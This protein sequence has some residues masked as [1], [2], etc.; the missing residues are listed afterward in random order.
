MSERNDARDH[1]GDGPATLGRIVVPRWV[2]AGLVPAVLVIAWLL[3]GIIGEAV[4]I[5]V[6]ASL[7]ALVLNPLVRL[8]ERARLPR[9]VG[10]FVV[11]LVAIGVIAGAIA[12]V[13]P[14]ML[15]QLKGLLSS[16]PQMTTQAKSLVDQIQS[17]AD[18]LHL[19]VNVAA[20]LQKMAQSAANQVPGISKGVFGLGVSLVRVIALSIIIVVISIYM[21]LDARN[22]AGFVTRHFPTGSTDDGE[23]YVRLAQ[24]A[25]VNYVKAQVLLSAALGFSAGLAMWFLSV[26]GAFPSASKYALFFGAWT[27]LMEIIPYVGP[28]LAAVPP[29]F[30]ALLHSPLSMVWVILTYLAIQQIEGHILT[31]TIMGSRFRVHPLLV[32][33]AILA[34]NQIHG[35][36]GMFIAIPLIPLAKETFSF[37][38]PRVRF[39]GWEARPEVTATLPPGESADSPG[40]RVAD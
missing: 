20:Q 31:P 28:V 22:I 27:A 37:L 34:G 32:I 29:S 35:V 9:Y 17:L 26:I 30:V 11:Y 24:T 12:L 16:L 4:F 14:P 36:S 18:R 33:F 38:R 1:A 8:L 39:A 5:F 19:H 23:K 15:T 13:V 25:V 10:V 21:L 2:Q 40:G 3:L 6:A 7:L